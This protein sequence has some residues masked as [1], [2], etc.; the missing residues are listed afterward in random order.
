MCSKCNGIIGNERQ[1]QIPPPKPS[2]EQMYP[3]SKKELEKYREFVYQW[4]AKNENAETPNAALSA[5]SE[6]S[7]FENEI[8]TRQHPQQT[9]WK[10]PCTSCKQQT[11]A[12]LMN[13]R[14]S[15]DDV[16]MD[17]LHWL[18]WMERHYP[19]RRQR[20]FIRDNN[21]V[22]TNPEI[23]LCIVG[24]GKSH[25]DEI[26]IEYKDNHVFGIEFNPKKLAVVLKAEQTPINDRDPRRHQPGCPCDACTMTVEQCRGKQPQQPP[27]ALK[28]LENKIQET[29]RKYSDDC[30]QTRKQGFPCGTKRTIL[31]SELEGWI[32]T[33]RKER[34]QG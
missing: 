15:K 3:I 31:I 11:C 12:W 26:S 8:L 23:P 10:D 4:A 34:E 30:I 5:Y 19:T 17:K 21:I 22:V 33:I 1:E 25:D 13:G 32:A 16:Y 9:E 24:A 28:K 7:R 27:D 6:L 29:K 14:N 18:N 20:G 2:E